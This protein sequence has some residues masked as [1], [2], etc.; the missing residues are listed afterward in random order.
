MFAG[1]KNLNIEKLKQS[2]NIHRESANQKISF[3]LQNKYINSPNS[4]IASAQFS[5]NENTRITSAYRRSN[6]SA[7]SA[8]KSSKTVKDPSRIHNLKGM[9]KNTNAQIKHR[10]SE[11]FR[12]IKRRTDKSGHSKSGSKSN[13]ILGGSTVISLKGQPQF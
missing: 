7:T 8:Q 6:T 3:I 9:A 5:Q 11:N 10:K 2:S 13:Y 12:K 1:L 4:L